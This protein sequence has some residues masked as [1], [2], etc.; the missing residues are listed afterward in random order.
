MQRQQPALSKMKGMKK[1]DN[2][3]LSLRIKQIEFPNPRHRN[4]KQEQSICERVSELRREASLFETQEANISADLVT[5]MSRSV[6]INN[7]NVTLVTLSDG[8]ILSRYCQAESI[9]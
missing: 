8:Q 1:N 2:N 3:I 5:G 6:T 4:A 7:T 9:H